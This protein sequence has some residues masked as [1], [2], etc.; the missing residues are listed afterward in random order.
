MPY[1]DTYKFC[2][3][4]KARVEPQTDS[5]GK[6]SKSDCMMSQRYDLCPEHTTAKLM[7]L[8]KEKSVQKSVFTFGYGEIVREIVGGGDVSVEGLIESGK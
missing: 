5:L 8:Y 7:L 4:C 2:L 6:C 3:Q 1:F